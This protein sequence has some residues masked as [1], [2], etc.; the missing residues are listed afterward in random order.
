MQVDP[1]TLRVYRGQQPIQAELTMRNASSNGQVLPQTA[2]IGTIR[3]K[4]PGTEPLT[5][6]WEARD[7]QGRTYPISYAWMP[8]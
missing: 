4:Q 3:V 5:L 8:Q 7:L 1:N 6:I 2:M